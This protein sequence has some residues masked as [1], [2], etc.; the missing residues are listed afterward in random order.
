MTT[1]MYIGCGVGTGHGTVQN[2]GRHHTITSCTVVT[3]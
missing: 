2:P 3:P 1:H